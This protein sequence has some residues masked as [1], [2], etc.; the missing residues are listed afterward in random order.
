MTHFSYS[1][2]DVIFWVS[3]INWFCFTPFM[4]VKFGEEVIGKYHVLSLY[5]D[6]LGSVSNS[7]TI[8][9]SVSELIRKGGKDIVFDVSRL[10]S[11]SSD[12]VGIIASTYKRVVKDGGS[13]GV[14]YHAPCSTD[15]F[16][17]CG[18]YEFAKHYASLEV[19]RN[20]AR[21]RR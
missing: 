10:S 18:V 12:L 15:I 2:G 20:E 5:G 7:S 1:V 6:M 3:F 13:V 19:L 16:N 14:V 21:R 8:N 9:S 17:V 11:P 4:V